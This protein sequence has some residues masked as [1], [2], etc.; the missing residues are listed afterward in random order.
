MQ[1]PLA[2][3]SMG[4]SADQMG[5]WPGHSTHWGGHTT[6]C[7]FL[8]QVQLSASSP[9]KLSGSASSSCKARNS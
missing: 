1:V 6:A 9:L 4:Q 5:A 2:Q 3:A 7:S 8:L